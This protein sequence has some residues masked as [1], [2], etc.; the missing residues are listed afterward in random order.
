MDSRTGVTQGATVAVVIQGTSRGEEQTGNT[1]HSNSTQGA[2]A[3]IVINGNNYFK[4]ETGHKLSDCIS[5]LFFPT[6][7]SLRYYCNCCSL[8]IIIIVGISCLFF[9][10]VGSLCYYCNCCSLCK[11]NTHNDNSTQGAT[12]AVVTHGTSRWEEQKGN[13]HN[14]N[15]TQ[16]ATVAVVTHGTSRWE[17]QTGNTHNNNYS[18]TGVL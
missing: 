17:E 8:C 13:T 12:V 6:T 15:S 18:R 10:A 16:G 5:C 2:T 3:E 7:G 11:G 1:H 14:D 4:D 9:P